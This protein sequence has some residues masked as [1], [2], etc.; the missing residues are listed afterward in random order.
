MVREFFKYMKSEYWDEMFC[1]SGTCMYYFEQQYDYKF[2]RKELVQ[3][4]KHCYRKAEEISYGDVDKTNWGVMNFS[5][6]YN[7]SE[8]KFDSYEVIITMV[9]DEYETLAGQNQRYYDMYSDAKLLFGWR[10][11]R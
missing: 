3:L 4:Y 7:Y 2:S 10:R 11:R 8:M 1:P 6:Y 9:L 5:K